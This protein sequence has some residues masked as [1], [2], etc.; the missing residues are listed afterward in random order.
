[1]TIVKCMSCD[2]TWDL[3]VGKNDRLCRVIPGKPVGF[4][5]KGM[6]IIDAVKSGKR[7]KRTNTTDWEDA[8]GSYIYTIKD[9]LA[10]DWEIE[11]RKI[12]IS[13]SELN[14]I[15]NEVVGTHQAG[16]IICIALKKRLFGND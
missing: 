16:S 13:E 7:R 1:M 12:E 15:L 3:L 2:Y 4:G 11:E 8:E 10:T 14:Q 9:I 6:N 5:V